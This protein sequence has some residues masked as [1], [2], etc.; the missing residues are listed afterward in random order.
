MVEIV[1]VKNCRWANADHTMLDCDVNFSHLQ[2][3]FVPFTAVA[4][5]DTD[6]THTIFANAVNGEYGPIAEFV[7]PREPTDEELAYQMRA[8]RD[9]LL[10][11]SDWT[12]NGDVPQS[13][14]DKWAPYRQALRDL[15]AQPGFPK[16]VEF[17]ASPL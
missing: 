13:T 4:A 9:Q 11:Q 15:P 8:H 7:P 12:Q 6:Y 5:G 2:E 3:E 10:Q 16:N 17:P 1:E 14:K